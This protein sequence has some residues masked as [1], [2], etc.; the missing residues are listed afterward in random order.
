MKTEKTTKHTCN[1]GNGP[2]FGRKTIGC[3]RCDELLA[4]APAVKWNIRDKRA[5]EYARSEAI[6]A[7]FASHEHRSGKCGPCCTFGEW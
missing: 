1:S 3:P 2:V 7:H 4:G 6:H 5:E